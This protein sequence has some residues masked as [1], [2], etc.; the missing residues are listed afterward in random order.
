M[1]ALLDTNIII[2]REA[3]RLQNEDIGI[4]FNWLD[5]LKIEKCIHPATVDELSKFGNEQ[6]VKR[7]NVKIG[8]YNT[9]KTVAPIADAV[10]NLSNKL[11]K[12]E[13]DHVDTLLLNEVYLERVD[14]L[15]T[16]D[17]NIHTKANLLGLS[18]KVFK[19]DEYLEKVSAENPGLVDY[20]VLAVKK[21]YFGEVN[22]K[23]SFFDSFREDYAEFDKWFIKKSDD[24]CYVCFQDDVLSAFLYIK[25]EGI[26]E[27]YA[28]IIPPFQRKKRL[29]VGTLKVTANG[30]KIGERF[31]KIIF[32]NALVNKVDEIYVTI[33]DKTT[34]H[35]RLI[36]L[37]EDYGFTHHGDKTS[38]NGVERVYTKPYGKAVI[39]DKA[40]P[41]IGYPYLSHDT[42]IFI[43][44][45][46]PDY[47]TELFP[48]S[49]LRTESPK[50]FVENEPH[51]NAISKVY[52]SRSWER[53]LQPG[54]RLMFYRTGG[55]HVG[56][57]TTIGV[58][59][60]VIT[61]IPDMQTFIRLCRKRSV[62]TDE[63]LV[64][65]WNHQPNN[66]PFIVNFL[67]IGS[68]KRR[69]NLKWL[70][71]NEVITDINSVPRGFSP[72]SQQD[73]DNIVKH[74]RS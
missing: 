71:D 26:D 64:K 3:E 2:H 38:D 21:Q 33:F 36:S 55:Y 27:N 8:N 34:E 24:I 52:I 40:N 67:Y 9:L 61:N 16:E 58:V 39:I 51:R 20:K 49:I 19:I 56:V 28:D 25:A 74:S 5:R 10:K 65:H 66:P 14:F 30:Y 17:K 6:A 29:K 37:F 42:N 59:E 18:T 35:E 50:D 31:L 11:D 44:P 62:F 23:D 13:N 15:I 73:F 12:T 22:L 1:R 69:P 46:Y 48:D 70:I 43:V 45:I 68:L 4:L 53:G 57:A 63:E 41:K 60:S 72:I 47:H 32:D 54:D 7:M